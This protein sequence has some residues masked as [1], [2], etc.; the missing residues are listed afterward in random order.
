[1]SGSEDNAASAARACPNLSNDTRQAVY[2]YLLSESSHGK[3]KRGSIGEAAAKFG[4]S[5]K[6][7]SRIWHRGQL[8]CG[9]GEGAADVSTRKSGKCGRKR[10]NLDVGAAAGVP[11]RQ[12]TSI[13]SL[14]SALGVP[15][16][17]MH[18]RI[19][20]GVMRPTSNPVKPF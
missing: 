16:S 12:R 18:K 17:T 10:T 20:E 14:A 2:Q 6:T 3:L 15:K 1:M 9:E 13:R 11:F 8:P 7:V 5:N 19:K 4:T